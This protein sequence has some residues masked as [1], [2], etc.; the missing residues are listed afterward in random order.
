MLEVKNISLD[1]GD[2]KNHVD[3]LKGVNF[4]FDKKKIYVITGPNGGGKSTLARVVMGIYKPT[5]G[6]LSLDGQD[7]T[8]LDKKQGPCA[9]RLDH[10][11]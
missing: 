8:N 3:I 10:N 1:M 5:G 6:Y 9:M 4:T 11:A 7:I 2:E